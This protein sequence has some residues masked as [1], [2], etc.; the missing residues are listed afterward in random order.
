LEN[1][2]TVELAFICARQRW[3]EI[4]PDVWN[5]LSGISDAISTNGSV[6]EKVRLVRAL[7]GIPFARRVSLLEG[8][9]M[10][11]SDWLLDEIVQSVDHEDYNSPEFSRL[12]AAIVTSIG[13]ANL[14]DRVRAVRGISIGML[15]RS[16]TEQTRKVV[17]LFVGR[18][19]LFWIGI[20]SAIAGVNYLFSRLGDPVS[21]ATEGGNVWVALIGPALVSLWLLW[22]GGV[23]VAATLIVTFAIASL[24]FPPRSM[25]NLL[26][27]V[28]VAF[29]QI[30]VD[31]RRAHWI[32]N[33]FRR[34]VTLF[35]GL[36]RGWRLLILYMFAERLVLL[37]TVYVVLGFG[38][39]GWI[40]QLRT[41]SME[42]QTRAAWGIALA[43]TADFLITFIQQRRVKAI[44]T[45]GA[46]V[47]DSH[48][49]RTY[50]DEC[51]RMLNGTLPSSMSKRVLDRVVELQFD[52]AE[53]IQVLK[54]FADSGEFLLPPDDILEAIDRV[55]LRR[56]Q[57]ALGTAH[58]EQGGRVRASGTL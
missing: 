15:L 36:N 43:V 6:L 41:T 16:G 47:V 29:S 46:T 48:K 45:K 32:R 37:A 21:V 18:L 35:L 57:R 53:V 42:W 4:S 54:R 13:A 11:T 19:L 3:T 44:L 7:A 22:A 50:L 49:L 58:G 12:L 31:F 10:T 17:I 28:T 51:I 20:V 38:I 25:Y 34:V 39:Y 56:R 1:L 27:I 30:G 8:L 52:E 40:G 23:R 26:V 5:T 24:V 33:P 14:F 2:S 55:D 9:T